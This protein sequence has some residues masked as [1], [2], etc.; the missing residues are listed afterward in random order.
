[1]VMFIF[2]LFVMSNKKLKTQYQKH[3]YFYS[4]LPSPRPPPPEKNPEPS[5]IFVA[6]FRFS[7]TKDC[8]FSLSSGS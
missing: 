1:M 8:S 4:L 6:T 3:Q 7:I 5:V 2:A